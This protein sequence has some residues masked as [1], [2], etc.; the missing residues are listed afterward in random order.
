MLK[1]QDTSVDERSHGPLAKSFSNFV[2]FGALSS[3]F[4]LRY[5]L[6]SGIFEMIASY[7]LVTVFVINKDVLAHALAPMLGL[8]SQT[9]PLQLSI[10]NLTIILFCLFVLSV[11]STVGSS[12]LRLPK[13]CKENG[14]S[15]PKGARLSILILYFALPARCLMLIVVLYRAMC[16]L[17][18]DRP[19]WVVYA[20]FI[21][22]SDIQNIVQKSFQNTQGKKCRFV[23]YKYA[24]KTDEE[25]EALKSVTR[26]HFGELFGLESFIY[27]V[28]PAEAKKL[29]ADTEPILYLGF[30]E[31][32]L[33]FF[34]VIGYNLFNKI[35]SALFI[36]NN[37]YI[38]DEFEAI[39]QKEIS[40]AHEI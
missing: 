23:D 39:M 33:V 8:I 32:Q 29:I 26:E 40:K 18:E 34:G 21:V 7:S 31:K 25:V 24:L 35:R 38:K 11:Y 27:K 16:S 15:P 36:F 22:S 13:F 5:M 4:P 17:S 14:I 2:M 10:P 30:V 37:R 9:F 20:P 12:P 3:Y 28:K 19:F 1:I 6:L